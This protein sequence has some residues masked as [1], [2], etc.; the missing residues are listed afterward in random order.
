MRYLFLLLIVLTSSCRDESVPLELTGKTMGTTYRI[1]IASSKES[2]NL[3]ETHAQIESKLIQI[4][5]LMSTYDSESEI[6]RFNRA[7]PGD[8]FNL[9]S[10]TADG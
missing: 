9:H 7:K 8:P 4:N 1:L 5:A 3:S 2:S 10:D 6:S